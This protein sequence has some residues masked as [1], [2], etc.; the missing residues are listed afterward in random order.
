MASLDCEFYPRRPMVKHSSYKNT[1]KSSRNRAIPFVILCL[2][3]L[4]VLGLK[5]A[6]SRENERRGQDLDVLTQSVKTYMQ[7]QGLEGAKL[8]GFGN[9]AMNVGSGEE[10][11]NL[12]DLLVPGY[13]S[14]MP[15]NPEASETYFI[16]CD[17]YDSGYKIFQDAN[18]EV[19]FM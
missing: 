5:W 9:T 13:L 7:D 17:D 2:G 16:S 8:P 11:F 6:D 10:D 1:K 12:C 18:Y 15:V 3:I 4:L 14:T 19:Q